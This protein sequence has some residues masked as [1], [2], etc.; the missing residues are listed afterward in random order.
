MFELK[1][2]SSEGIQEALDKALRY[3]LLNS[4]EPAESICLDILE[5]DPEN[6]EALI[7]LILAITDQFGQGKSIDGKEARALLPRLKGD[8]E[9]AYYMGI[10][11]ERQAYA[12]LKRG[13]P[14]GKHDAYEC[15]REA[16]DYYEQAEKIHPPG[17]DEAILHWNCSA[18]MIMSNNLTPRPE[19]K[20]V[21]ILE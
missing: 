15:L 12:I 1:L 3:R 4:P 6:Q 11:L 14:G 17:N 8:Y 5:I 7:A 21:P 19:D 13:I 20:F 9:R 16:L 18:R 10:I 2:L